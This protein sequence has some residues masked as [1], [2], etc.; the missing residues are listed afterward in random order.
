LKK[1]QRRSGFYREPIEDA[2]LMRLE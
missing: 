2:V 1:T